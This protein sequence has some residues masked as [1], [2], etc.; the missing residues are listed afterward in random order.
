VNEQ[1]PPFKHGNVEQGL[2][3]VPHACPV[4]PGGQTQVNPFG[5]LAHVPPFWHGLTLQKLITE[6]VCPVNPALQLQRYE[7]VALRHVPPFKHGDDA[8]GLIVMAHV[9]PEYGGKQLQA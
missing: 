4:N 2:V 5:P 6:H 9:G 3:Y 1:V 7:F 8:Q